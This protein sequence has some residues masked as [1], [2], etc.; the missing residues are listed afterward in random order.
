M[1]RTTT[2]TYR[3]EISIPKARMTPMAW[4]SKEYG[5]PNAAN[6]EKYIMAFAKS[7][8]PGGAN[9]HITKAYGFQPPVA[10]RVVHQSTGNVIAT[11]NAPAF[12]VW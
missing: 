11:W 2:P 1:G 8:K 6:L 4:K 9:S 10:A 7:L 12:M 3:L 5:K